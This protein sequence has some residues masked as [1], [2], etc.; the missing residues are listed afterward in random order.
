MNS[1]ENI[2]SNEESAENVKVDNGLKASS[3]LFPSSDPDVVKPMANT[4]LIT[5]RSLLSIITSL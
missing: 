1:N 5:K 4:F 2:V 3:Q